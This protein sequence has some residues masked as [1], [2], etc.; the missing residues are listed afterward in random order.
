MTQEK[1]RLAKKI[2]TLSSDFFPQVLSYRRHLHANPELSFQEYNTSKFIQGFLDSLAIPYE[3]KVDTGIVATINGSSPGKCIVLRADMDALPI[4]EKNTIDYCSRN[5]GIMH[6][7]GHDVHS[8]SLMGAALIINELK[9][10]LKGSVRLLFQP[11]EEKLPGG[12]KLMIEEGALENPAPAAVF[13]Q[14]VFT[15][16]KPGQVGFRAGKYM[17]ST[18]EIYLTIKGKGGHAAMPSNYNSPLLIASRILLEVDKEFKILKADLPGVLAFGKI[19]G[20]GATNVIPE[21]VSIEGTFRAM[22]ERWRKEIHEWIRTITAEIS[23]GMNG[24][25]EVEI[26]HGYPCLFNDPEVTSRAKAL[27]I[28]Y[29]GKENVIDLEMRMTAED[30]AYYS[31]VAPSCFYRLG[32]G[33]KEKNIISDVHTSTFNVD[34]ECLKTGMGLM[35]WLAVNEVMD[36]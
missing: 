35:A 14:H 30:F 23:R 6:A 32:T 27:A 3:I 34:E 2:Q 19:S 4:E 5:K 29:L 22:D 10:S 36:I 8:A 13:G 1:L 18:D 15:P 16:L 12:A 28:E 26:R 25:C 33:N 24:S 31:Q 9:G 17:A 21:T 7:C 11:G 20:N